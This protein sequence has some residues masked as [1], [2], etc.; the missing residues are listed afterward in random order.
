MAFEGPNWCQGPIAD[1][2]TVLE[3]PHPTNRQKEGRNVLSA[4]RKVPESQV[5]VA[6]R[7]S[8]IDSWRFWIQTW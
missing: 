3:P 6:I 2:V 8:I 4:G 7:T 1:V 5:A